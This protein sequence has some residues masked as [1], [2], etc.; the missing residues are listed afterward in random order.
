MWRCCACVCCLC[1]G[2]VSVLLCGG[3]HTFVHVHVQ[4]FVCM[5]VCMCAHRCVGACV[6]MCICAVITE[7]HSR[8]IFLHVQAKNLSYAW[9]LH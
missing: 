8:I 6:L 9:F 5:H 7:T 2:I 3:V 1:I 4:R